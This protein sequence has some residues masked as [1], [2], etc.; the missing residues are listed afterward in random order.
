MR[1]IGAIL[2][3]TAL[4]GVVFSPLPAAAFGIHLGPF[5]VHVPFLGPSPSSPAHPGQPG[6]GAE[7][8]SADRSIRFQP[9]RR[10]L[11]RI[12]KEDR[13]HGIY[14]GLAF[15]KNFCSQ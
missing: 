14:L 13:T 1:R 11:S 6:R 3:I 8:V 9:T 10:V 12:A 2:G 15:Q 5:Y 4:A 7:P